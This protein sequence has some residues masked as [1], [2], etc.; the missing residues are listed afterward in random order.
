MSRQ[1]CTLPYTHIAAIST[2]LIH[3]DVKCLQIKGQF[4]AASL[5]LLRYFLRIAG[6]GIEP[7]RT[8][9]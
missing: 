3:H 2:V 7:N 1:A 4:P 5:Y 8:K 6:R 9:S